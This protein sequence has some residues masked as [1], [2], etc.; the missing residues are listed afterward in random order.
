MVVFVDLSSNLRLFTSFEVLFGADFEV[1]LVLG[2]CFVICPSRE[3]ADKAV[4]A[5][6]NKKTL[7]GV[8]C[9]RSLL[10]VFYLFLPMIYFAFCISIL[11]VQFIQLVDFGTLF[12]L[13]RQSQLMFVKT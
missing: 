5:C 7:P 6:H 4:N 12:I 9:S 13:A 3:E 2:C 8:S 10:T 1:F 11:A